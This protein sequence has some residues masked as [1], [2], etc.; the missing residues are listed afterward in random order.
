METL[1]RIELEGTP[2]V[3]VARIVGEVDMSNV[4][5]TRRELTRDV[6]NS[7]RGL[8]VDVS[9]VSYF[10]SSGVFLLFE[11]AQALAQ[12][13]QRMCLVVRPSSRSA[14]LLEITGL[15]RL[16]PIAGTIDDAVELALRSADPAP[17][18]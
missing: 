9:D 17:P 10:D 3:V 16:I 12:R 15:D 2:E 6:P 8:V 11:L 18:A 13:Q 1:A 14:R 4:E 5:A 7:A